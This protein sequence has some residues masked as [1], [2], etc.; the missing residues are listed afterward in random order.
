MECLDASP[1]TKPAFLSHGIPCRT[2]AKPGW[3]WG[4]WQKGC[5]FAFVPGVPL[6]AAREQKEL[7]HVL[8]GELKGHPQLAPTMPIPWILLCNRRWRSCVLGPGA[9]R[10]GGGCL[11]YNRGTPVSSIKSL[12]K[13]NSAP[14]IFHKL[15]L[16]GIMSSPVCFLFQLCCLQAVCWYLFCLFSI[17]DR[18]QFP[19][20]FKYGT[21]QS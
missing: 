16:P 5:H 7:S 20:P 17:W 19:H 11:L 8:Q 10:R 9:F 18:E 6:K 2:G 4:T 14:R 13:K 1:D 3:Q 15:I 12:L 21:A